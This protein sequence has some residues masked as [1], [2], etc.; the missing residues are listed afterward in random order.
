[1]SSWMLRRLVS[2]KMADDGGSKNLRNVGQFVQGYTAKHPRK[3]EAKQSVS[4]VQAVLQKKA[5]V[6]LL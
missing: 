2:K 3:Q 4:L 1:M 6:F 5:V